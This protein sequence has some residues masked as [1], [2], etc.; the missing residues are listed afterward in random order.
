[1]EEIA[2]A[3]EGDQTAVGGAIPESWKRL[4]WKTGCYR[5]RRLPKNKDELK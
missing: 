5:S 4:N 2:M 1:L 3:F